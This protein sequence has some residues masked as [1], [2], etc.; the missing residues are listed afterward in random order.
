M[1]KDEI[2]CRINFDRQTQPLGCGVYRE[3]TRILFLKGHVHADDAKASSFATDTAIVNTR[4]GTVT[5]PT[6]IA[7]QSSVGAV[8]SNSFSAYDKGDR[9]IYK[10]GVH[11]RLNQH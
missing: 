10:G 11:A 9:V 2:A 7:G 4:T 3:D 5:G 8:Q 6:A 1:A